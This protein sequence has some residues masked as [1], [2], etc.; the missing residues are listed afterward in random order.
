MST[1]DDNNLDLLR[2]AIARRA[3]IVLSLPLTLGDGQS[4]AGLRHFKSRFLADGGDGLWVASVPGEPELVREL[5]EHRHPAG[6]CFRSGHLK[7]MFAAPVLHAGT[8]AAGG[9]TGSAAAE[10]AEAL[11]LRF[12]SPEEVRAVQRRKNFRVPVP[13]PTDLDVRLWLI[14][15]QAHVR[16]KPPARSEVACDVRDISV[17]GLGVTLRTAEGRPLVVA[18]GDRVRVQLTLRDVYVVLEGRLRHPPRLVQD[19]EGS[20][21]AGIQFKAMGDGRDDRLAVAHLNKIVSDLQ[22]DAIRRK[23]LGVA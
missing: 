23:K 14:G 21:R 20:I 22:R 4:I 1:G 7:V 12:P 8:A 17:G 19:S 13:S 9:G 6:V 11:L 5:V 18:A 16:D 3:G 2:E 15:E 10:E